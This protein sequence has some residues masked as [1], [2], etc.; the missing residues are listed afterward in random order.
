MGKLSLCYVSTVVF[1]FMRTGQDTCLV[2]LQQVETA[3]VNEPSVFEPL[4]FYC[5]S[6]GVFCPYNLYSSI[7]Q[8]RSFKFIF[9]T[10][11]LFW[12]K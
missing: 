5:M 11:I 9:I 12:E 3:V 6:G 7:C 10:F 1:R 2:A 8:L 4:K